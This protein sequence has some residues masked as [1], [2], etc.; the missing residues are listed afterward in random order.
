MKRISLLCA[1]VALIIPRA[2]VLAET[3][4]PADRFLEAYFLVQEGDAAERRGDWAK[5]DAKF[6]G[7]AEIL[8][9][10][11]AES[12]DWNPHIIE[13]RLRYCDEHRT[14]LKPKLAPPPAMPVAPTPVTPPVASADAERIQQMTAELETA[15]EQIRQLEIARSELNAKLQDALAKVA[16]SQTDARIEEL[17]KQNK[18]LAAQLAASQTQLAE[19]RERAAQPA[20]E[21][22]GE[23][24]IVTQLRAELT[25]VRAELQQARSELDQTKQAYETAKTENAGLRRSYEEV[26]AQ[27]QSA[28]KRLSAA[29][30]IGEQH[31]DIIRQLRKE[32][33][34]L[35]LIADRKVVEPPPA[36]A[37]AQPAKKPVPPKKAE[38]E[39]QKLVAAIKA[40]PPPATKTS[41]KTP[42]TSPVAK[43]AAEKK[44]PKP[45][46]N[47]KM[48]EAEKAAAEIRTLLNEA[49]AAMALKDLDTAAGKY[50]AVLAKETDN[51]TALS[52][53]GTVRYQQGRL[54]EALQFLRKAVSQAPND[55][56]SRAVVGIIY[57]RKGQVEDAFS[58]L[59]RA[60][61]L[62]PRNAEAHNYLG[63]V[64]LVKGWFASA[65]QEMQRAVE[66]NPQ[67]SDAH[68]NLAVLYMKQRPPRVE[69]AR[70]HYL[71]ALELGAAA[72][73]QLEALLNLPAPSPPPAAEPP[74]PEAQKTEAPAT[75]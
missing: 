3:A 43:P 5:A 33:A 71:R 67:Y 42:V 74:K 27:L 15:R 10:L 23:A 58:E 18:E 51:L 50:E 24:P 20:P 28:N 36:P 1:L 75:P 47:P 46:G 21:P 54:D 9:A 72:D 7:A 45:A 68:F 62:D 34:L 39:R 30:L 25:T 11:K 35:Q 60:V 53:L 56:A 26:I 40:P 2:I 65:Q 12:P 4:D 31:E 14:A 32:N 22:A 52:G 69:Q 38:P 48:T 66:L 57:L 41:P 61:A 8:A 16:P 29:Q 6:A 73:P 70:S 19:L 64:M 37:V 44:P 63:I 49:R 55:A 13:F 17:L 59:T